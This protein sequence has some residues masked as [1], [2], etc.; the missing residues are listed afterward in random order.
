[1]MF[2]VYLRE[3]YSIHDEKA[4]LLILIYFTLFQHIL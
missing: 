1:M 4:N 2:F 3:L